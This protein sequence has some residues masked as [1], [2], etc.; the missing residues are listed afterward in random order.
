MKCTMLLASSIK[1]MAD[2]LFSELL[3]KDIFKK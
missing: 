1:I 3:E 2:C